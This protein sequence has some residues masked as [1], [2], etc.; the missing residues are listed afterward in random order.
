MN[1]EVL[2]IISGIPDVLLQPSGWVNV[3]DDIRSKLGIPH[4]IIAERDT[5]G[6]LVLNEL[7][8]WE[9]DFIRGYDG[10][11]GITSYL[12]YYRKFDHWDGFEL[13]YKNTKPVLVSQHEGYSLGVD[14]EF[15]EWLNPLDINENIYSKL[16]DTDNGWLGINFHF[17]S[18]VTDNQ[19]LLNALALIQKPLATCLKIQSQGLGQ[20]HEQALDVQLDNS[21]FPQIVL[22]SDCAII[23]AS[24]SFEQLLILENELFNC[25]GKLS[26]RNSRLQSEMLSAVSS[27]LMNRMPQILSVPSSHHNQNI[28][29]V[30][31]PY[32]QPEKNVAGAKLIIQITAITNQQHSPLIQPFAQ[33]HKLNRTQTAI[34]Y[35]IDT[36]KAPKQIASEL[37]LSRDHVRKTL[38]EMYTIFGVADLTELTHLLS[39]IHRASM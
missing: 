8:P 6:H 19:K 3:L 31:A 30:L 27:I 35:Q 1:K 22:N 14:T 38:S 4:L 17:D 24:Q 12:E 20:S 7:A 13:G 15:W 23:A 16:F 32:E 21:P 36:G 11:N 29:F 34:L 26:F 10:M 33:A 28:L 5:T 2:Q 37:H 9:Y 18:D 25:N 39:K